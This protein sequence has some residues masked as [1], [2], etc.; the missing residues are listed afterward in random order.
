M[1]TGKNMM[2]INSA[3]QNVKSFSLI[4][5]NKDC[6]YIEALFDP[7]S[8]V[9]AVITKEKKSTFHMVAKLDPSGTPDGKKKERVQIQT[10]SEYYVTEETDIKNFIEIFAINSENFNYKEYIVNRN[11][12]EVSKIITKA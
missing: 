11:K 4:S 1:D 2:L 6:P 8:Q 9:L 7:S 5:T 10:Y 3:F 12:V